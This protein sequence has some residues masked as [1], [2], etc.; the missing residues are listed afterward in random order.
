MCPLL[1][2]LLLFFFLLRPLTV[3][4]KQ[5][6]QPVR[7]IK[8]SIYLDVYGPEPSTSLRYLWQSIFLNACDLRFCCQYFCQRWVGPD[9]FRFGSGSGFIIRARALQGLKKLLNKLGFFRAWARA[10]DLLHP[11]GSGLGSYL[12]KSPSPS[13]SPNFGLGVRPD[14][15]LNFVDVF[16]PFQRICFSRRQSR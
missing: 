10:R 3:L 9:F 15:S 7:A 16:V 1:N 14:P 13:P 2:S 5:A 8:Q 6:R 4:M 12:L 11:A